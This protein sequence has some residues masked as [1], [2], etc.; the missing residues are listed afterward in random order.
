MVGGG[1]RR[2]GEEDAVV[3]NGT[4][5]IDPLALFRDVERRLCVNA[6]IPDDV[7]EDMIEQVTSDPDWLRKMHQDPGA[8]FAAGITWCSTWVLQALQEI[9]QQ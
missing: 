9:R 6:G 5:R 8:A 2:H 1:G 3:L 7:A 4:G